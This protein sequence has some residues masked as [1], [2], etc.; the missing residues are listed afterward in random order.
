VAGLALRREPDARP[1]V[2]RLSISAQGAARPQN[3]GNP[4]ITPD[5]SRVVYVGDEG[6]QLFVRALNELEPKA[7]VAAAAGTLLSNPFVSPDGQWVGFGEGNSLKKVSIAGG[8]AIVIA[9]I[10]ARGLTGAVWLADNTIVFSTGVD[11]GLQ[12]VSAGGGEPETLTVADPARNEYDHAWPSVLPDGRGILYTVLMRTGG[13]GAAKIAVYDFQTNTSTDL[14]TGGTDAAYLRSGHL[15]Y[16]AGE[17]LWAVPFDADRRRVSGVAVPVLHQVHRTGGG[18][19]FAISVAGT[20]LVYA[21]ASGYDPS[22]RTLSWIDRSGKV[23]PLNVP[24][25]S[26]LQPRFSHDGTRVVYVGGLNLW[27]LDLSREPPTQSRLRLEAGLDL[28]PS[29]SPDDQW[30]LFTSDRDGTVLKIWRQAVDSTAEPE[31]IVDT[32]SGSPIVTPDVTRLI[33]SAFSNTNNNDIMEMMLDGSKLQRPLVQTPFDEENAE[34]SDDQRWL[35]Y[36]SN[37]SGQPEVYVSPYPNT[38]RGQWQVSTGGGRFPLWART[39]R[40]LFF[41]APDGALMGVQVKATGQTWAATAPVKVLAPGYWLR[42][43]DQTGRGRGYDIS[44]DG[45]RFLVVT[46]PKEVADPPEL[47]VIQHWD[48]ELE[49]RVAKK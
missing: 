29:W 7:I 21:R 43:A 4:A 40:E 34:I 3:G 24:Q 25:R 14:L 35:A 15:V 2:T 47:V 28:F 22:L 45:K 38:D 26:Y 20:S 9:T 11:V 37:K 18:G 17:T 1:E 27:I 5:G 36:Q 32:F 48:Q 8:S 31:L 39:S 12:R 30:I 19:N 10:Y 41:M 33:Y 23:E 13:L 16:V 44:P 6:R 46:P 42:F 49:E